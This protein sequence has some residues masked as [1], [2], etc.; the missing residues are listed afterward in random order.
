MRIERMKVNHLHRPL[1]FD[2]PRACLSYAVAESAGTH[3]LSSRVQVSLNPESGEC[4]LDTGLVP[5]HQDA[6]TGRVLS[7]MDNLGWELPMTLEPRTRYYWRVFVRT[8]A[9]EEGWS[10]WDWFETAKQGEAWQAKAIGSPLGRDV[11]PVF[12]KRFTVRPGAKA[13][14]LYILGLGMY[15]AY[16]NGEKLGEEV[17]SP[18]F[19]TYDTCLHYQTLMVWPK[20]GENVLTVMLGDGWYKGHYSLKPRM[21]DYGTDYSLL[22]ELHIPYQ[23]GTE[24]LVCTDE[25]WQ[26]ARG[27]VQ[28]DSIY[29]GET[30]DANLLNLAPETNAVPF[31]LNMALLTPRRAPLLRVQ[32]KRACQTVPGASEILDFGQNMVGWVE[33]VC[34]A[35]KGTVVTLKFAEILRDGK[36]Y[37]ENLRKAKCT[38]TYVSDGIRRVVRP[39]FTFFGFRYLSVEGM[40]ARPENFTGCVIYSDMERT[41][42]VETSNAKVNRLVDNVW[43]SQ[44]GNFVDIPTDCPQRDERMGWT[45]DIQ[46]FSDTACFNADCTAFLMKFMQDVRSDQ[47]KLHGSVPFVSPMAGYELAGGAAWSDAA[48][49]VPWTNY[50]HSGDKQVLRQAL[51]GMKDWVDYVT[52]DCARLGHGHLWKGAPQLGDWLALDGNSV[53]GGTD[54]DMIATAYYYYSTVLTAKAAHVLDDVETEKTYAA[55]AQAI[56]KDFQNEYFTPT[57][58]LAVQTQTACVLVIY[59]HLCPTEEALARAHR[60]LRRKIDD[61][62]RSLETGFVGTPWLLHALTMGG[63]SDLAYAL[64]TREEYPGWLYEV[65]RGATTIWERWNSIEPD[66]EMNRDGMNSFNHYAYGSVLAWM[67][68]TMGGIAPDEEVPA[69]RHVVMQPVPDRSFA[70]AQ[71]RLKTG[72]GDCCVQWRWQGDECIFE[73]TVPFG[74][75]A[76]LTLP[77]DAHSSTLTA[78]QYTFTVTLPVP[79]PAGIDTP[80]RQLVEDPAAHAV[81]ERLFPRALRGV[82][83]QYEMCTMRQVTESPFA[84]L[85]PQ[86]IAELDRELKK[87]QQGV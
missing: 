40:E 38:F 23:D 72:N 46:V 62:G 83:F 76:T 75:V 26:I 77:G 31:P 18:G 44:K 52:A 14:R 79:E 81:L 20:E 36:L 74:T 27:A 1:G 33:F 84:E 49:V 53:Y 73:I 17:L 39:H 87:A 22:A 78:G 85:S 6:R 29:D 59:L 64:L 15:E 19:H 37:R 16:L 47:K 43:W 7:G 35:P 32:E 28:M 11:H 57:G 10:A 45:G 8:D 80:W 58:N 65:N 42:F 66:G 71:A 24:Q 86:A 54:R 13:A 69:F 30:L 25:S 48:T 51:P 82:A 56:K 50:V 55:L 34:D 9:H 4:L 60:L 21:K 5:M 67:V 12:V 2:M 3:L 61:A 70:H 41:G 63:N 68:R